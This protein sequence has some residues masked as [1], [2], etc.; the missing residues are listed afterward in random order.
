MFGERLDE[1]AGVDERERMEVRVLRVWYVLG[2]T[3][4]ALHRKLPSATGFCENI[5]GSRPNR[6]VARL[7]RIMSEISNKGLAAE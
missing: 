7:F 2:F 3:P 6:A 4:L 1:D 5:V